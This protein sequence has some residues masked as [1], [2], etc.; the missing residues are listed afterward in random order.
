MAPSWH[1]GWGMRSLWAQRTQ[2]GLLSPWVGPGHG[3]VK[4][5]SMGFSRQ[6]YWSGVPL[7]SPPWYPPPPTHLSFIKNKLWPNA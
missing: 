6:E 7:P 1:M 3:R 2:A 5:V 4:T